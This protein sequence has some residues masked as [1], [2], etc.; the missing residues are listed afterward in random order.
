MSRTF[1][2]ERCIPWLCSQAGVR[3]EDEPQE[4]ARAVDELHGRLRHRATLG[5][6]FA[7]VVGVL[8]AALALLTGGSRRGRDEELAQSTA[9]MITCCALGSLGVAA[10]LLGRRLERTAPA[11]AILCAGR[12]ADL[13][14]APLAEL[15]DGARDRMS[16]TT[17]PERQIWLVSEVPL[18]SECKAD[19]DALLVRCFAPVNGRFTEV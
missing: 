10:L 14:V 6:R 5:L 2:R 1:T 15:V 16:D 18:S 7:G 19:A 4:V 11:L 17:C 8:A 3:L 12:E 13:D 9:R